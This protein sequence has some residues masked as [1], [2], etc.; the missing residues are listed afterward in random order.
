M[1]FQF[2]RQSPEVRRRQM[3][4]LRFRGGRDSACSLGSSTKENLL[5]IKENN[6]SVRVKFGMETCRIKCSAPFVDSPVMNQP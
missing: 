1:L 5:S 6:S 3:V 2:S 4:Q